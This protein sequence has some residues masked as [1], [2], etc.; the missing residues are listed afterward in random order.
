MVLLLEPRR[1]RL[2]ALK[3]T[4]GAPFACQ[5]VLQA[6]EPVCSLQRSGA[7]DPVARESRFAVQ[8]DHGRTVTHSESGIGCSCDV[9]SQFADLNTNIKPFLW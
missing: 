2:V 1:K 9:A 3:R 4:L 5:E 6:W 8:L 7:Q